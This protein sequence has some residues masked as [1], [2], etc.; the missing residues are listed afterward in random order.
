MV[1]TV[2]GLH[3]LLH[4]ILLSFTAP[5]LH[6]GVQALHEPRAEVCCQ[7]SPEGVSARGARGA[8]DGLIWSFFS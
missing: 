8:R 6:M 2:E 5:N 3:G 7:A 4:W 1:P